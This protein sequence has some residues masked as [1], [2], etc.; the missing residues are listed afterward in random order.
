MRQ[1]ATRLPTCS[2]HHTVIIPHYATHLGANEKKEKQIWFVIDY[3]KDIPYSTM[4]R[5]K[6][7]KST[8]SWSY[9]KRQLSATQ[10]DFPTINPSVSCQSYRYIYA[11]CGRVPNQ[12]SPV[13]GVIKIDT[14]T[15]VEYKWY[16]EEWEYLGECV[17]LPKKASTS[18]SNDGQD[19][20]PR[21]LTHSL[22]HLLTHSFLQQRMMDI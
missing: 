12:S 10:L 15:G 5:Y 20:L 8:S 16:G 7:K 13:Q 21:S 2:L 14:Q 18:A 4:Y 17:F 9:E 22:T 3:A 19:L 1:H 6:L 11:A